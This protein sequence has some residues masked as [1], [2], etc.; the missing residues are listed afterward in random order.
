MRVFIT[1]ASGQLGRALPR[2]FA[3]EECYQSAHEHEDI[4]EP[5]ITTTIVNFKPD[6]IIHAAA[7][8]D[9]DGCEMQPDMAFRVNEQGTR[10]VAEAARRT[11]ALLVYVSTDYVYDGTKGT[12]YIETDPTNP[13]N[14]YGH[15]KLAGERAAQDVERWLVVRTSWVYGEGRSN[16]VTNVLEWSQTQPALRLVWDKQGSPTYVADLAQAIR[17]LVDLGVTHEIFHA[18]GEGVCNWVEYGQ[19]ILKISGLQKEIQPITFDDLQ[20]PAARPTHTGLRSAALE[21]HGV[22]MRPWQEAL[23]EFL[24]TR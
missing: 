15:S 3:T 21:K 12:A 22:S 9:V 2:L 14:V 10:H 8:T 1:G 11:G 4:G 20:R 23:R 17:Y 5:H 24:T 18:S 16:F 19:E 13:I 7:M 6:V